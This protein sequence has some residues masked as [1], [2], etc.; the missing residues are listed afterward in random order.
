M[1]K[2]NFNQMLKDLEECKNVGPIIKAQKNT[3][4]FL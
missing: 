1:S 2:K 4:V 3:K